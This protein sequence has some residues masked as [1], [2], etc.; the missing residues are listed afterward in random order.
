ME[1]QFTI[2][3]MTCNSCR[4]NVIDEVAELD[5]VDEVDVDLEARR[6]R[7]RGER[8]DDD[9]IRGAVRVAGYS[10]SVAP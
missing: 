5:G 4:L 1:R 8:L 3:G 2:D 6:M 7:V 10:A 9:A